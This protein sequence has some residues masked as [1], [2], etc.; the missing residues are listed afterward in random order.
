MTPLV[1]TGIHTVR[2]VPTEYHRKHYSKLYR[3]GEEEP[4][5]GDML[6]DA[7]LGQD[8]NASKAT[9]LTLA[10]AIDTRP[11]CRKHLRQ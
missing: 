10:E 6:Q 5:G 9:V 3:R 11:D 4:E 8:S 2:S 1:V 7:R